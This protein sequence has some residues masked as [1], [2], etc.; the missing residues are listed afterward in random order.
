LADALEIAVSGAKIA[1]FPPFEQVNSKAMKIK[2]ENVTLHDGFAEGADIILY[3]TERRML[4][5][6]SFIM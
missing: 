2:F 5:Y 3:D 6:V 4:Y 1:C